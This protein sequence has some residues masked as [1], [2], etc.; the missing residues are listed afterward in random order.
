MATVRLKNSEIANLR[1]GIVRLTGRTDVVRGP[2]GEN[3]GIV[4]IPFRFDPR[5]V[6]AMAK[7]LRLVDPLYQAAEMARK[8]IRRAWEVT[9]EGR[10]KSDDERARTQYELDVQ[11]RALDDQTNEIELHCVPIECLR[12]AENTLTPGQLAAIAPMLTGEL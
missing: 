8:Q 5:A 7:T 11:T 1:E 6:Y 3:L 2:N 9:P 4:A 10:E 12:L